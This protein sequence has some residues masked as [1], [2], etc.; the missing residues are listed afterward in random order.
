M[1]EE[2]EGAAG[3]VF[4]LLLDTEMLLLLLRLR[5]LPLALASPERL[6]RTIGLDQIKSAN[7]YQGM[8]ESCSMHQE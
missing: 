8:L 4:C 7:V 5:S 1:E 2:E 3:A 6:T